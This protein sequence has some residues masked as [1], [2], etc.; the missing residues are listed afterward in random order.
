LIAYSLKIDLLSFIWP[1]GE[2]EL[3]GFPLCN[4]FELVDDDPNKY[5][6]ADE[7]KSI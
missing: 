4:M 7:L 2:I 3:L 1:L 5:L 6:R